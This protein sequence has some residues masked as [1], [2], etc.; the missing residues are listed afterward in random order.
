MRKAKIITIIEI[1]IVA[2]V[3]NKTVFGIF[4][5]KISP[6]LEEPVSLMRKVALPK[7]NIMIFTIV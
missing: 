7:S 4:S 6:T 1:I 2:V 5:S 3:N